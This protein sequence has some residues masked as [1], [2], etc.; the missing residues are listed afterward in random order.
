M[1]IFLKISFISFQ[2][3]QCRPPNQGQIQTITQQVF[4]SPS[5]LK[6]DPCCILNECKQARHNLHLPQMFRWSRFFSVFSDIQPVIGQFG[7]IRPCCANTQLLSICVRTINRHAVTFERNPAGAST[8]A[9][10]LCV[11][12]VLHLVQCVSCVC[13][14]QKAG[15]GGTRVVSLVWYRGVGWYRGQRRCQCVTPPAEEITRI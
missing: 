7:I 8:K 9:A 10:C 2:K 15:T 14:V 12:C 1:L 13:V 5:L 3:F 11:T 4:S 6:L